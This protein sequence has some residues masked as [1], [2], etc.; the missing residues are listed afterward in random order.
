MGSSDLGDFKIK[1]ASIGEITPGKEGVLDGE[2]SG[3][4]LA[5]IRAWV[6]VESAKGSLK[7]KMGVS[8]K[9][10]HGHVEVPTTL[11]DGSAIWLEVEDAAGKKHKASF[12]ME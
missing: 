3:G 11:P 4:S 7:S 2:V 1:V 10:F 12:K 8:G 9:G 6:G 5:A